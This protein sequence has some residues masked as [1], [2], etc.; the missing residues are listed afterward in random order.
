M[1]PALIGAVGLAGLGLGLGL[2]WWLTDISLGIARPA[3]A[4][5]AREPTPERHPKVVIRGAAP[6]GSR[7]P[8][9]AARS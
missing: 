2:V 5:A 7:T 3:K 8:P 6:A 4:A 1:L 9:P